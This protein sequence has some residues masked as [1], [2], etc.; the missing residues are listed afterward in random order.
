MAGYN[1]DNIPA[2]S[3]QLNNPSGVAVD[4]AGNVYIADSASARSPTE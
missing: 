4:S 2:I 1:G 3:A